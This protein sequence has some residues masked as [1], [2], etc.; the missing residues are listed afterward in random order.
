V[1]EDCVRSCLSNDMAL[2][3]VPNTCYVNSMELKADLLI[4]LAP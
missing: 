4:P 1:E 2:W 3:Y